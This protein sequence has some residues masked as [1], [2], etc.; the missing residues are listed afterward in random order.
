MLRSIRLFTALV[1]LSLVVLIPSVAEAQKTPTLKPVNRDSV[2]I[3]SRVKSIDALV[4]TV[5]SQI[6]ASTPKGLSLNEKTQWNEHG[7]WLMSVRDR[8]QALSHEMRELMV[9]NGWAGVGAEANFGSK[10][11]GGE[12]MVQKMAAMNMETARSSV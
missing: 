1:L 2:L 11:G 8:Y 9:S 6:I 12:A 7:Q 4:S 5:N 3:A 10:P